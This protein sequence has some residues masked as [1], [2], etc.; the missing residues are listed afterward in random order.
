MK[1]NV[2]ALQ[3]PGPLHIT[4]YDSETGAIATLS[5]ANGGPV[6]DMYRRTNL[7]SDAYARLFMEAPA[8]AATLADLFE[9]CAMVHKHWG[10][11]NNRE[12]AAA[13]IE[14]GRAILDRL[15]GNSTGTGTSTGD[16]R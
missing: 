12:Q 5:G 4:A 10:D 15:A 16:P 1:A 8:M 14:R 6:C 13:A 3:A 9:H 2:N 11:G 7:E